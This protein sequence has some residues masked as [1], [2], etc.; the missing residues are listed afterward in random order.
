VACGGPAESGPPGLFGRYGYPG[1]WS[2]E[3]ATR[4]QF[5]GDA[6]ACQ[7]ASRRARAE[8]ARGARPEAADRR[9]LECM[10]ERG[11]SRGGRLA[12]ALESGAPPL[13]R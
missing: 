4:A 5:D 7:A 1:P 8:A 9:F 2:R 10:E 6:D 12:A 13:A 11:W 3:G